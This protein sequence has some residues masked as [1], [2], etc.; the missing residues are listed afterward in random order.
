MVSPKY[1]KNYFI[2]PATVRYWILVKGLSF[3]TIQAYSPSVLPIT[4]RV[5]V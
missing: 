1:K 3:A 5:C 4:V 2:I